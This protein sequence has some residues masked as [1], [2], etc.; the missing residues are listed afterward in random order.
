DRRRFL[1][2]VTL[3]Q[4]LLAAILTALAASDRLSVGAV[5][6]IVPVAGCAFAGAMRPAQARTPALVGADDLLGAMSLG[7]AQFNL[8]RV[9][10]PAL[11]GLV[12]TAGG[13]AWAFGLNV[14]SFGA[15][16]LSLTLIRIPPL[17]RAD[18]ERPRG[19]RA[20]AGGVGAGG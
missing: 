10:G 4:T 6:T 18:G 16:L 1:V 5:A 15:V 14:A 20:G 12:I 11:A 7:A 3:F 9:V 17:A 8:G 19:L 13:L 2:A